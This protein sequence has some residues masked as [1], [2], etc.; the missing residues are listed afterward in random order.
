MKIKHGN[1]ES[2][3]TKIEQMLFVPENLGVVLRVYVLISVIKY[4]NKKVG[5]GN[6]GQ[7]GN[8]KQD[9]VFLFGLKLI[10]V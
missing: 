8:M 3:T 2:R 5:R 9:Y 7:S 10:E 1:I 6:W 4:C